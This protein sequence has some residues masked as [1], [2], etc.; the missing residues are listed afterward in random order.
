MGRFSDGDTHLCGPWELGRCFD[1]RCADMGCLLICD[2]V[3]VTHVSE[4]DDDAWGR[5][6][7]HVRRVSSQ[8]F[9]GGV[10]VSGYFCPSCPRTWDSFH[11]G[12]Q[13]DVSI[14]LETW[15]AMNTPEGS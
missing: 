11:S 14:W 3:T 6:A 7:A 1:D 9:T 15:M 8:V 12:S 2:G 4:I 5:R 10:P 13:D